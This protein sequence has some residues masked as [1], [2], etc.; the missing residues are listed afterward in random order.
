M[1]K[2][3]VTK[4]STGEL[5]L[6][7]LIENGEM[8]ASE[9]IALSEH[10]NPQ[11]IRTAISRLVQRGLV[12]KNESIRPHFYFITKL[13]EEEYMRQNPDAQVDLND[14]DLMKELRTEHDHEET[15]EDEE[16]NDTEPEKPK[17]QQKPKKKNAQESHES[18]TISNDSGK[19]RISINIEIEGL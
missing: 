12:E 7:T 9:I 6:Q 14:W 1:R 15:H 10:N 17:Q 5:V 2:S 3:G 19:L 4:G 13:G 11:S 16:K 8:S 18:V